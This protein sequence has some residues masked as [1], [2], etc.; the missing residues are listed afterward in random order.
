[1]FLI[2]MS[3]TGKSTFFHHI[4]VNNFLC[5]NFEF[6]IKFCFLGGPRSKNLKK[7]QKTQKKFDFSKLGSSFG[8]RKL[9]TQFFYSK[10]ITISSQN[11]LYVPWFSARYYCNAR[12]TGKYAK[13][14]FM[15]P[16][17]LDSPH[18]KFNW[19]LNKNSTA[20]EQKF[21]ENKGTTVPL[22]I[23]P[24]YL[25]TSTVQTSHLLRFS[26][27]TRMER[28]LRGQMKHMYSH[29]LPK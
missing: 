21:L 3:K 18:K 10:C 22:R 16:I 4:F 17:T 12:C 8:S 26:I 25:S 14:F 9:G 1:M 15:Q 29:W 11:F 19:I 23:Y 2:N 5:V 6:S 28:E 20:S 7:N 27:H 24:T 13:F